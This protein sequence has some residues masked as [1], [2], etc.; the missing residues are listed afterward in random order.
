MAIARKRIRVSRRMLFTWCMLGGFIF[1]FAP[2]NLTNKFQFAFAHIFRW[3]LSIGRN[4]SLSARVQ[5]PL[6]D[7]VSRREYNQL[8]NYLANIIEQQ[9][10]EH[11]KVEKLSG[12]R[13]RL[14]LE[15][16]KLVI[17]DVITASIDGSHGELIINRGGYD[18][19][20]TGQFVLGDNSV[21]G[22]ISDVSSR[23]AKV[24]LVSDP[25][26]KIAVRI[27]G[28]NVGGLMQ[29]SG[30]NSAMV[31]LVKYKVKVRDDIYA[32]KKPG[33]LD[34]P[35]IVGK[36]GECRRNEE[37]PLL[38]NITAEPACEIESLN[39]VAVIIVNSKG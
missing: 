19:L 11:Q 38:W 23:T 16:A 33:F 20:A 29:G 35:I 37:N 31:R 39:D 8:Q 3:P 5:Q 34:A 1:L 12:L 26:S 13:S 18:G 17:A 27:A 21:I 36:V 28:L 32:E 22:R 2:Q 10:G 15:G 14:P 9:N 6:T 30:S 24:K 7:V 4:I 25:T